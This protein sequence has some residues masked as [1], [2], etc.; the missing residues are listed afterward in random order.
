MT[1]KQIDSLNRYASTRAAAKNPMKYWRDIARR[2]EC[3]W[4][5]RTHKVRRATD[6]PHNPAD[7]NDDKHAVEIDAAAMQQITAEDIRFYCKA[8]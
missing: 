6:I 3:R 2:L 8:A 5:E 1:V 7:A 4:R